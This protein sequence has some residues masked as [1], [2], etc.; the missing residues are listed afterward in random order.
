[1]PATRSS[2]FILNDASYARF[3]QLVVDRFTFAE[4]GRS[5]KDLGKGPWSSL[6]LGSI[7]NALLYWPHYSASQGSSAVFDLFLEKIGLQCFSDVWGPPGANF[8][9]F[10]RVDLTG[11]IR[12]ARPQ[13]VGRGFA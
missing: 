7:G 10:V 12:L 6:F 11:S 1:M 4:T 9:N 5:E 8:K 3:M 2:L 13:V